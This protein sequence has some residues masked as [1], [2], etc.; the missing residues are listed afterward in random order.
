MGISDTLAQ[1]NRVLEYGFYILSLILFLRPVYQSDFNRKQKLHIGWIGQLEE[2]LI[3][4]FSL[5]GAK[6][7]PKDERG[8]INVT[9]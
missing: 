1:R 9:H 2:N 6:K 7:K 4:D 8:P 3:I 5:A